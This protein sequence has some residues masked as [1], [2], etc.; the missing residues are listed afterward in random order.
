MSLSPFPPLVH[1]PSFKYTWELTFNPSA[2]VSIRRPVRRKSS[3]G[4]ESIA[5]RQDL[6]S[7]QRPA[8]VVQEGGGNN[9]D[10]S[11][12]GSSP[13]SSTA[14]LTP[15]AAEGNARE[16]G[17]RVGFE[18]SEEAAGPNPGFGSLSRGWRSSKRNVVAPDPAPSFQPP[19]SLP[20]PP[21]LLSSMG[22]STTALAF[23]SGTLP[24]DP[25]AELPV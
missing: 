4:L 7:I 3:V 6:A 8:W 17:G 15:T 24:R 13:T 9:S 20:T 22:D 18:V 25:N 10:S 16:T 11:G 1:D 5:R 14:G 2:Y 19:P 21:R 23:G 12:S